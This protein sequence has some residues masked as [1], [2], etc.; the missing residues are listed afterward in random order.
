MRVEK[1]TK[2][3]PGVIAVEARAEDKSATYTLEDGAALER[4]QEALAG[5]GYPADSLD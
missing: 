5:I 3:L 4:V 1:G 2:D